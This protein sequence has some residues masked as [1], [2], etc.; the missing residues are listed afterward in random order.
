MSFFAEYNFSVVYKPGQLNV[1]AVALSRRP[2][3]ESAEQSNSEVGTTVAT[4]VT[5]VPSSTLLDD[6]KR[7][8]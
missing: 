6:L 2:D 7:P 4:L 5:G 8:T 3:F 1:V